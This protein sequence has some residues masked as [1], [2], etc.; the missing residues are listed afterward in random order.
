LFKFTPISL[1]IMDQFSISQLAQ[2][3][4]IKAHTIRIWEQRYNAL[5]PKRSEGNTRYYDNSQ[6]RR[7]LNMV[8]LMEDG[9]KV[10]EL[11]ALSDEELI[12]RVQELYSQEQRQ[13]ADEYYISQLIAAGM[14]YD[15]WHF[16]KIFA[17][18]LLRLGIRDTYRKVL[19]PMMNRMGLMWTY[20]TLSPAYEHFNSNL[21]KQKFLTA[22]DSVPP[23]TSKDAEWLLFLPEHEFHELGLLYAL[24]LIKASGQRAVYLGGNLPMESIVTA[25][26]QVQPKNLLLFLV[27]NDLPEV[28]QQYL[29]DLTSLHPVH[30]IYVS[31]NVS[32]LS[33]LEF[34]GPL[35]WLRD[36]EDLE[37]LLQ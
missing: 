18:C 11:S 6:L 17:H 28:T 35:H 16:E 10:S 31:G 27:H 34:A 13:G 14:N 19:Y 32:L 26:E 20:G 24:Y 36:A 30:N 12:R 21:L 5:S 29:D 9:H 2:L 23:A 4:G 15:E 22:I 33:Q 8:S 37:Q 3:S 7:L 25:V 1:N